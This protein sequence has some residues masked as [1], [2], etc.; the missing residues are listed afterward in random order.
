MIS[1]RQIILT[2]GIVVNFVRAPALI[3][4]GLM[5]DYGMDVVVLVVW[6]PWTHCTYSLSLRALIASLSLVIFYVI[7]QFSIRFH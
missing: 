3:F 2:V 4:Q 6:S 1:N 5:W 7:L